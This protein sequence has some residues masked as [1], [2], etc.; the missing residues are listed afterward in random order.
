[1]LPCRA[2]ALTTEGYVYQWGQI[3][4]SASFSVPMIANRGALRA[5]ARCKQ[6]ACGHSHVAAVLQGGGL[7]TWGRG[8]E[9]QLGHG[10]TK[11]LPE[12]ETVFRFV[13]QN[14]L[15]ASALIFPPALLT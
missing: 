8:D 7:V 4:S 2:V 14:I 11:S 15:Q 6:V 10:N 3:G 1:M 13:G 5:N 9:G 12:P